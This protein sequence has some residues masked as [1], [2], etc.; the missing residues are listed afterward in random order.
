MVNWITAT[1][2][3]LTITG[4][5]DDDCSQGKEALE[6]ELELK[7][8][9]QHMSLKTDALGEILFNVRQPRAD[10]AANLYCKI[11]FFSP[12]HTPKWYKDLLLPCWRTLCPTA[13]NSICSLLR[14]LCS[15]ASKRFQIHDQ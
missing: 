11:N 12:L 8:D 4:T 5:L 3:T 10:A 1:H 14:D 15:V 9:N 6:R 7:T 13:M 2:P